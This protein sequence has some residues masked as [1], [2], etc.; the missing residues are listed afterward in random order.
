MTHF[1]LD[2]R[3]GARL[4]PQR[5]FL[6]FFV[7]VVARIPTHTHTTWGERGSLLAPWETAKR[8]GPALGRRPRLEKKGGKSPLTPLPFGRWQNHAS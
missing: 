5:V 4:T 8:T 1:L 7:N 3:H 6:F 2:G